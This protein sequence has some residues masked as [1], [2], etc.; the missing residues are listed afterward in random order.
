MEF[1]HCTKHSAIDLKLI[2][3]AKVCRVDRFVSI[4]S[5]PLRDLCAPFCFGFNVLG[6]NRFGKFLLAILYIL[7][8]FVKHFP[9]G[10]F[11]AARNWHRPAITTGQITTVPLRSNVVDLTKQ[12]PLDQI[13]C[14][15]VFDVVVSLVAGGQV[16]RIA[17]FVS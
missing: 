14:I 5:S 7:F 8:D 17:I 11:L 1:F 10:H 13:H 6:C 2:S 16:N 12:S 3:V 9:V 15:V 4:P